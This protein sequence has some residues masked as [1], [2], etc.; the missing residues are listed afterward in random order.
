[1][2]GE[3]NKQHISDEVRQEIER[4]LQKEMETLRAKVTEEVVKEVRQKEEQKIVEQPVVSE[5]Q[6]KPQEETKEWFLRF[7]LSFRSQH[8]VLLTSTILL[9]VTGLPLKFPD[10]GIAQ[11]VMNLFGGTA[12]ARAWHHLAALGLI[13]VGTYHIFYTLFLKQ[14]K[15]DF[16]ELLPNKKD[17]LDVGKQI[18]YFLGFSKE[19]AK[20]GRFS[21]VEK[22]DYWAVYWGLVIMIG[23][24]A[25]MWLFQGKFTPLFIG[26]IDL[27]FGPQIITNYVHAIAR[28]VHSDEA[29]LATLA[30]V[31]W[32]MYNVHLNPHK[33]PMSKVWITGKLSRKEMEDEHP[34]ELE[35]ILEERKRAAEK[36]ER[37]KQK[38]ESQK[39]GSAS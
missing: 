37:E 25:I 19:K 32:H 28:E 34:L 3:P 8:L 20:F 15:K 33:F 24:G 12:S 10:S 13:F 30:I 16:V 5:E 36:A 29:M 4:R 26:E 2:A 18:K 38:S 17:I 22:F 11:F 7:G 1:M 14:G 31:I 23:S 39:G 9:I 6:K 35:E 21:Y 27:S